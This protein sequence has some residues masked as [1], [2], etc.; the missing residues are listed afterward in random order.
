MD[1]RGTEPALTDAVVEFLAAG[2]AVAAAETVVIKAELRAAR[3][4]AVRGLMMGGA[5][6]LVAAIAVVFVFVAVFSGLVAAGLPAWAA[7]LVMVVLLAAVAFGFFLAMRHAFAV[8]AQTPHRV[9]ERIA[10]LPAAMING[11]RPSDA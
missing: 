4:S 10:A 5:A 3:N 7:A 11:R 1:R 6:A 2:A 9:L 8:V